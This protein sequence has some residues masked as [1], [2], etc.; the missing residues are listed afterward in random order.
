MGLNKRPFTG[1]KFRTMVANADVIKEK[2]LPNNEMSGPVFKMRED[3]RVTRMGR[4]SCAN[5]VWMS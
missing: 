5:T 3:P 4:C 2:L 1:Y